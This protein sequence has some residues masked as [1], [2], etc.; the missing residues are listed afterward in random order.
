MASSGIAITP[1]EVSA[2]TAEYK[3][4]QDILAQFFASACVL[5]SP[6]ARAADAGKPLGNIAIKVNAK[7]L[8][9]AFNNWLGHNTSRGP[10]APQD[11]KRQMSEHG[12]ETV[13][14]NST[15]TLWYVGVGLQQEDPA[16]LQQ[17]DQTPTE[18]SD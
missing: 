4:Q 5:A 10:L 13:M 3:L 8:H 12:Y 2:A 11:F 7:R 17:A 9:A 16:P 14:N 18:G 6:E 15:R 1:D